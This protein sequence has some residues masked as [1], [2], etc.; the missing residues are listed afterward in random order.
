MTGS[1]LKELE[2]FRSL[3]RSSKHHLDDELEV[4]AETQERIS[5]RTVLM[6]TRM[7]ESKNNL[8]K[9]EARLTEDYR[10][11]EAKTTKEVVEAKV[12]R[13]PARVRA[14]EQWMQCRQDYELWDGLLEAWKSKGFGHRELGQLYRDQYFAVSSVGERRERDAR[15]AAERYERPRTRRS[16]EGGGQEEDPYLKG[17]RTR[18]REKAE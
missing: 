15:P 1:E 7:L 8:A 3:L 10:A 6:N 4:Q 18:G 17:I 12:V 9:V 5:E 16:E 14:W 11:A 13:D 2:Q